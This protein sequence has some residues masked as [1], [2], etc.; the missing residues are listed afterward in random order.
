MRLA[1]I[2]TAKRPVDAGDVGSGLLDRG[3][4]LE[5]RTHHDPA[6]ATVIESAGCASGDERH[7]A[8]RYPEINGDDRGALESLGRHPDDGDGIS[9]QTNCLANDAGIGVEASNPVAMTEYD[10]RIGPLRIAFLR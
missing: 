7:H 5:T 10:E 9:V 1:W 2:L 8:H 3:P 6:G 4:R